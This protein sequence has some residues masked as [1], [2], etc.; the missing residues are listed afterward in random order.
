MI[1]TLGHSTLP[2]EKFIEILKEYGIEQVIDIRSLP[3]S[4]RFPWFNKENLEKSLKKEGLS[5]IHLK[6][7]GGLRKLQ[8]NSINNY[9]KNKSFRAYADYM[10][11]E[12]FEEGIKELVRLSKKKSVIICSEAVP[13]KC[14]RFLVSDALVSKGKKVFHI[15]PPKKEEH[16][17]NPAAKISEGKLSY[18]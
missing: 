3:G 4:N 17:I 13:W 7:L 15:I 2:L 8:K 10:Q 5:Y 12:D 11:T 16:E 9:W 6:S 14:H 18:P 1:Y